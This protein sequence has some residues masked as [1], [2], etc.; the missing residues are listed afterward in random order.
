MGTSLNTEDGTV[1]LA[2]VRVRLRPNLKLKLKC[3]GNPVR[4]KEGVKVCAFCM[5]SACFLCLLHAC[6]ALAAYT[7]RAQPISWVSV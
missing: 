1:T 2:D 7:L 4:K 6:C 3:S 5:L